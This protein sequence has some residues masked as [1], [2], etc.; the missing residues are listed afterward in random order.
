MKNFQFFKQYYLKQSMNMLER[1]FFKNAT[2][3]EIYHFFFLKNGICTKTSSKL[4]L[5]LYYFEVYNS[6]KPKLNPQN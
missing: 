6:V 3:K 2:N 4:F 1:Q 5:D